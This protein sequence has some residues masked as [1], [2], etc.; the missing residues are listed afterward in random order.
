MRGALGL[1]AVLVAIALLAGCG[2]SGDEADGGNTSSSTSPATT[3][4][5][6][7]PTTTTTDRF[8]PPDGCP[9]NV[10]MGTEILPECQP[11]AFVAILASLAIQ[12]DRT[13]TLSNEDAYDAA[14]TWCST[15]SEAADP[16][17]GMALAQ[18]EMSE[19][20]EVDEAV[21]LQLAAAGALCPQ[22]WDLMNSF[23]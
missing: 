22:Y 7:A 14:T 13:I 20:V 8:E 12:M 18:I 15:M 21:T 10:E 19:L 1:A 4:T 9:A 17:E 16:I 23:N 5:T 6:E 3:S 11:A 2:D